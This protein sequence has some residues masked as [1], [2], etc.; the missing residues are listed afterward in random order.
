[1]LRRSCPPGRTRRSG[2]VSAASVSVPSPT[3]RG[4]RPT[5]RHCAQTPR[6][7][8][9]GTTHL[10]QLRR[11]LGGRRRVISWPRWGNIQRADHHL[12]VRCGR[13][14]HLPC[15]VTHTGVAYLLLPPGP[16]DP[17]L[18]VRAAA[19]GLHERH[20]HRAR[21]GGLDCPGVITSPAALDALLM[22]VTWEPVCGARLSS[23]PRVPRHQRGGSLRCRVTSAASWARAEMSSL[24]NTCARWACTVRRDMY[25]RSPIRGLDSPS[26][27]NPA[28]V[29]SVGV[30]LRQP[31]CGRWRAPRRPRLMPISRSVA[32]ARARSRAAP[33]RS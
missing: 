15:R 4:H 30:R 25:R 18:R 21:D 12:P 14:P 29:S 16:R 11:A 5:G 23:A 27:T 1:M 8:A 3:R 9:G 31:T 26:A 6:R 13:S 24:A 7:S 19:A 22:L 2:H 17:G 33:S 28:T 32:S 20:R 10:P